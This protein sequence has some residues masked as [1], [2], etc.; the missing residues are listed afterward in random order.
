MKQG[1][2]FTRLAMALLSVNLLSPSLLLAETAAPAGRAGI[3]S[4]LTG[5]VLVTRAALPKQPRQP[6]AL[7]FKD[8]VFVKDRIT[9]KA[10]SLVRVLMGGKALVT[11]RELSEFTITEAP[12]KPSVINIFTGKIAL[13]VVRAKLAP[14]EMIQ[15]RTPNA[16]AGVRG[17]VIVVE[18][19]SVAGQ[20]EQGSR[21]PFSAGTVPLVS[22]EYQPIRA[23]FTGEALTVHAPTYVTNFH[24]L[25]GSID[26][27]SRGKPGAPPVTLGAGM[28][29]RVVGDNVGPPQP[30]PPVGQL[31]KGLKSDPPHT[32]TPKETIKQINDQQ[33]AQATTLAEAIQT[34][35]CDDA[36]SQR[37][38]LYER[39][40]TTTPTTTTPT[41]LPTT[42]ATITPPPPTPPFQRLTPPGNLPP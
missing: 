9:T 23:S 41:I 15:V 27:T 19:P 10:Q 17:T 38:P 6:V 18:V 20:A 33:M 35:R 12:G 34:G 26:I 25:K 3:V 37:I 28:S 14:G 31:V 13:A 16:V 39:P 7:Q 36:Y 22:P 8:D 21:P 40:C 24:T 32:K 29:L 1:M 2:G 11:V 42:G 30:S 5:E 4:T